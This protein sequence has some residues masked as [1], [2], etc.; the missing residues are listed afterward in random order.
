MRNKYFVVDTNVLV[1][2][3]IFSPSI[4]NH[5]LNKIRSIGQLA[6]SDVILLEYNKILLN[7]KFEKYVS[8]ARRDRF[9]KNLI[10]EGIKI[11][12]KH[13]IKACRD[14]KDD[15]YLELAVHVRHYALLPAI[16]ICL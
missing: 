9:L 12:V 1:S 10:D 4:P 8:R 14:P 5:C 15:K 7:Y 2:A 6:Y 11:D 3:A 13:L 16:K